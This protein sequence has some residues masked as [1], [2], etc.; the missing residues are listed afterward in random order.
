MFIL[1]VVYVYSSI[2]T[3]NPDSK[4]DH[5]LTKTKNNEVEN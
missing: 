1:V 3:W 5:Y 2:L 4:T